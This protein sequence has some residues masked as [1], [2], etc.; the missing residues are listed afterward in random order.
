MG[1][2]ALIAVNGLAVMN[3]IVMTF[4]ILS[5]TEIVTMNV[6]NAEKVFL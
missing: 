6:R 5:I 3:L 4:M 1:F 2:G